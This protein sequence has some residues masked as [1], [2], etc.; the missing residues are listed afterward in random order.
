[1]LITDL[2]ELGEL[3]RRRRTELNLS[4]TDL[5]TQVGATRQWV[6]RLEKGKNDINAGRLLAVIGVLD[7]NLDVRPP[8]RAA[9]NRTR[10]FDPTTLIPAGTIDAITRHTDMVKIGEQLSG[11]AA[12]QKLIDS[13]GF[14]DKLGDIS[15]R[16]LES[17]DLARSA[18]EVPRLIE[19]DMEVP[20]LIES[21][22]ETPRMLENSHDLRE[23][24]DA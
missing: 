23:D 19:S 8:Q 4:Q 12:M 14:A 9:R 11:T 1:M 16:I 15:R 18:T 24:D 21:A 5:A 13:A 7:M 2:A 22:T 6:S 3:I 20:N 10:P 17:S